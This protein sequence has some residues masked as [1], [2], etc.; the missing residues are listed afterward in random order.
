MSISFFAE[1]VKAAP[2]SYDSLIT[3]SSSTVNTDWNSHCTFT[4][5]SA[6][7]NYSSQIDTQDLFMASAKPVSTKSLRK[8]ETGL[9]EQGTSS[10]QKFKEVDTNFSTIPFYN[11]EWVI[12]PE[13][14]KKYTVEEVAVAYCSECGAKRKKSSFKFCP[15]R[16]TKF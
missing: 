14:T 1:I 2:K 10:N 11:V 3:R 8:K 9:T 15:H 7:C 16:G 4:T 5:T 6:Y 13:S 12:K